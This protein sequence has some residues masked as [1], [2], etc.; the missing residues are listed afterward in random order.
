MNEAKCDL[1]I[2]KVLFIMD[3]NERKSKTRHEIMAEIYFR[4]RLSCAFGARRDSHIQGEHETDERRRFINHGTLIKNDI[5]TQN[6]S[7]V[8]CY[9]LVSFSGAFWN[10]VK[11]FLTVSSIGPNLPTEIALSVG[12]KALLQPFNNFIKSFMAT[13]A[14]Y[15][16][17][18]KTPE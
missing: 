3:K 2:L 8:G 17:N 16:I 11:V 6:V 1:F 10:L 12:G 9:E 14:R 5:K 13:I 4:R 7:D 15:T 18:F